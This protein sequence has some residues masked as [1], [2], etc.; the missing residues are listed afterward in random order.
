MLFR[1]LKFAHGGYQVINELCSKELFTNVPLSTKHKILPVVAVFY[2]YAIPK[3]GVLL[4][5]N[6][7][8]FALYFCQIV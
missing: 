6:Y 1:K 8:V 7:D 4:G 5:L 2:C 3:N